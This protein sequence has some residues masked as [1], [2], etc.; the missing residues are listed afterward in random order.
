MPSNWNLSDAQ[1]AKIR[2][3]L[4]RG[5]FLL[6]D[7]FPGTRPHCGSDD[8]QQRSGRLVATG[9]SDLGIRLAVNFVT[10]TLTH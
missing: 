6:G 7:S 10:Y 9:V 1:A 5:G 4:R 8:I 3:Y 2:Q